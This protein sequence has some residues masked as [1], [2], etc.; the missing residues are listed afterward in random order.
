MCETQCDSQQTQ[1]VDPMLDNV[2]P[3]SATLAHIQIGAKQDTVTQCWANVG[4]T[5]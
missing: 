4:L 1:D 3:Q 2:G 5:S